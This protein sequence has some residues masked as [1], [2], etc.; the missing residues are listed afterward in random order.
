MLSVIF[1]CAYGW[2]IGVSQKILFE[3]FKTSYTNNFNNPLFGFM[4]SKVQKQFLWLILGFIIFYVLNYYNVDHLK[5]LI[6]L[7]KRPI[8]ILFIW[9]IY[10]SKPGGRIPT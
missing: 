5:K 4:V 9:L 7:I 8:I 10:S 1:G 2:Q 6:A 3:S